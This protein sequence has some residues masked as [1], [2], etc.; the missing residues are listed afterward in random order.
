MTA[1]SGSSPASVPPSK[2]INGHAKIALPLAIQILVVIV[3]GLVFYFQMTSTIQADISETRSEITRKVDK[4]QDAIEDV[5]EDV[6]ELK[7][8]Q[9]AG[10]KR[11]LEAVDKDA[12]RRELKHKLE[13]HG[14]PSSKC[15]SP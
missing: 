11:I 4:N 10:E 2:K 3:G 5:A 8:E 13:C 7:M 6:E 14:K 1:R 12:D 9:K 15:T